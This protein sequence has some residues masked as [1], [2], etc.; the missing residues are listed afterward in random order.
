MALLSVAALASLASLGGALRVFSVV[1]V[2][3]LVGWSWYSITLLFPPRPL[4]ASVLS[5]H[6]I[7]ITAEYSMVNTLYF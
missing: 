3:M 7:S 5:Q 1:V 4:P 2:Q 6:H